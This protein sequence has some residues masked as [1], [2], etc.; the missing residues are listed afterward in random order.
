VGDPKRFRKKY[1]TLRHPWVEEIIRDELR[2]VGEYGLR[3]K[4]ELRSVQ[5]TLRQIRRSARLYQGLSGAERSKNE[6][7]LLLKLYKL[8][9]VDKESSLDDVLSLTASNLLDRR[10]QTIVLRKGFAGTMHQAR[11]L[12]V[13][14]KVLLDGRSISVPGYLVKRKDEAAISVQATS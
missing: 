2:L 5:W 12:I 14:K 3:N 9:L 7:E 1:T 6:R 11:Q 13:H 4:K 10:L 8:S